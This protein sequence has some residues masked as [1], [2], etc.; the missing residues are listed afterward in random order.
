MY[1]SNKD[2]TKE[3]LDLVKRVDLIRGE[4]FAETFDEYNKIC[5]NTE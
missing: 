2:L 1:T 3:F 4:N 5:Y